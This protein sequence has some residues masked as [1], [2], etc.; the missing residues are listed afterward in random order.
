V[1]TTGRREG[2]GDAASTRAALLRAAREL[3]SA[4][5]FDRTT[6]RAIAERADVNQALLFRYFGSKDALFTAVLGDEVRELLAATAPEDLL[7]TTVERM[8]DDDRADP[9]YAA[10]RSPGHETALAALRNELGAPYQR[11]FAELAAR[12]VGSG[13]STEVGDETGDGAEGESGTSTGT[14][15][16][17]ERQ[18]EG[19]GGTTPDPDAALRA[20]LLLAWLF[21]IGFARSVLRTP[22]LVEADA[23]RVTA[24]MRAAA[25]S[26][27]G[28]RD[29]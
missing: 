4:Q 22:S 25:A 26:L 8:F 28:S 23:A 24:L 7:A 3:F 20:D 19:E 13:T 6:V 5:G 27:L 11:V 17:A 10:L 14:A 21:G 15:V 29:D 9:F 2:R 18:G 1:T 16:G 12:G